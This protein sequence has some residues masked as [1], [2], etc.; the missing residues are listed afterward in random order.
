VQPGDRLVCGFVEPQ[1]VGE[2]F[3]TWLLHI[4]IVPWFRLNDRS[5]TIADGLER[6][7]IAVEPFDVVVE[8][9]AL[10]GPQRNRPAVLI[11]TPTPLSDMEQKVRGY[12]HKKRAWLVDETTKRQYDFR[13]H[14][15]LQPGAVLDDGASFRCDRLYIVEQ[16]GDYKEI[17]SKIR[18]G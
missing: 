4:T 11:K 1:Q 16:K 18:L 10:F 17:V 5:Q 3:Q 9:E 14:V 7:L 12:L 13:P 6:A 2:T 8:G 15:T